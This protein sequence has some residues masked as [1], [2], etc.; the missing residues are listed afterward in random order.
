MSPTGFDRRTFLNLS[1]V[2]A[3]VA[4]LPG[5]HL[6]P[7]M[8]GRPSPTAKLGSWQDLYRERWTWDSVTRGSHG[9]LNCRSACNWDIYV[10]DGVVVREEQAANYK[11]SE[12]GVPDFN[13]RGCQKGGCY[14]E[15]MYGPTRLTAPMKRAGARGEGKWQRISWDQAIH[16]IAEKLVDIA[17][18]DGP[19]TIIQDLGPH[20]DYGATTVARNRFFGLMG[21]AMPDDWAEIGDLNLGATLTFGMPH[22]GGSSDEWFLSDFLVVWMMNPSVTQIPDAHFLYEARYNGAQL[23]VVDPIY[24]ATAI[25]A[26]H[27]LPLKPGTDAGLA[28]ATARHIWASG[29]IDLNYVREQ[30]DFPILV[31]LDTGRFLRQSDLQDGGKD[32]IV[33]IWDPARRGPVEA[34]GCEGERTSKIGL[35]GIVPPI[36]GLFEV[37]LK[38]GARTKVVPV[39]AL[40]KEHLDPWT[41]E[42]AAAITGLDVE[43]IRT[44]AEGFAAAKRPMVL[45]SWGSNRYLHSDHMNRAKLLCL[46][47]RGA[48]G[49]QKG[50]GYHSTGWIGMEGFNTA[51]SD[52][53]GGPFAGLKTWAAILGD[54]Y[55]FGLIVDKIAGRKSAAQV[56]HRMAKRFTGAAGTLTNSGSQNYNHQGIQGILAKEED[57]LYPRPLAAYVGESQKKGWM[58]VCPAPN[59]PPRAWITGGSNVLRRSNMPQRFLEHVW[60]G[61]DLVVD[62]NQKNTFTGLHADYLLPAAGYYEKPGIKYTVAYIPYVHYCGA[63]VRP[64]GQSKD[65]WEIFHLLA[66]EVQKIARARGVH[67][68][69]GCGGKA[70]DLQKIGDRY[71]SNGAHGAHD[72]EK[73]TDFVVEHSGSTKGVSLAGLKKTGIAKFVNTGGVGVQENIYNSDWEGKGVLQAMTDFV[74]HKASYMTLTGRQQYY[75]DHPWFLE[76]GESLPTHIESPKAGGDYPFQLVSCHSRWSVHSV[77]RDTPMLLRL[78]RGEPALYLNPSD[79]EAIGVKDGE[80]GELSNDY[81]KMRMRIKYSTMVRPKVA[82]FFHAWEPHQFPDHRSYKFLIPGL[83]NPMH[84][85]GGDGGQLGFFFGHFEPGTH[86]QDTRVGIAPWIDTE[87][88]PPT[89]A[90]T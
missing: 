72:A 47:L 6:K 35:G 46:S 43:A 11:A 10:K 13:P 12:A 2:T 22:I 52:G 60:P 51:I 26:D 82:Y 20:F 7:A 58:P 77:W 63:A 50:A 83:M 80:W 69:S 40:V 8:S 65:E 38:G 30:T 14:T 71:S 70:I 81:G 24:S 34:P 4:G 25:H 90:A 15:V 44:F 45:S 54:S 37:Q 55:T 57:H 84:F 3:L 78:Q 49:T 66:Q 56:Q 87:S 62:I 88:S 74:R 48:I 19:E 9:W 76:A 67:E 5:C 29:R 36:E 39:G 23:T 28:L 64:V 53:T 42:H 73:V 17:E 61:L 68:L 75:I 89:E 21:A 79:A 32:D 18:K 27:W 85:A 1:G 41:F 86:V 59:R 16:E 33:Y 31:R